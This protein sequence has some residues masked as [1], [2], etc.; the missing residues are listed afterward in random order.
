MDCSPA[1]SSVHGV[2]QARI[3]EGACHALFQGISPTQGSNPGILHSRCI[4]YHL[5][6]Q[7]SPWILKWVAYLFSKGF[8]WPRNRTWVSCI[9]GRFFTSWATREG[10]LELSRTCLNS[11]KIWVH[12]RK[13]NRRITESYLWPISQ[14]VNSRLSWLSES[15]TVLLKNTDFFIL[16]IMYFYWESLWRSP[17]IFICMCVCICV[18]V[19]LHM[20]DWLYIN[21]HMLLLLSRFSHVWLCATPWAAA[22]QAPPS[23]GFSRQEHWSGLPFPSPMHESKKWK[24]S[25]SVVSDS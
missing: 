20:C 1:G 22:H 3:L 19:Y 17:G 8:S 16:L 6:H 10:I 24:W 9:A 12:L 25:C 18:C 21:I 23:L 14:P 2:L 5:S 4:L 11:P 15:P 13:T 7:G